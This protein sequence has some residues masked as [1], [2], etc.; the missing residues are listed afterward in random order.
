MRHAN[1]NR[2]FGRKKNQRKALLK[3]L[4]VAL[5]GKEKIQTTEAK[6]KEL[7]PHVEKLVSSAKKGTLAAHRSLAGAVGGMSAKKLMI[8]IGPRYKER[9]GGYLR[10]TKIGS[11]IKDGSPQAIIEFV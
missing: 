4:S 7:R 8:E 2:K 11:R 3:A 1:V 5:I 9:K 6:A 10:I